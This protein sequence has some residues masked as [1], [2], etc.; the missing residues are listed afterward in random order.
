VR[1]V[2]ALDA[3]LRRRRHVLRHVLPRQERAEDPPREVVR[4]RW[5][6]EDGED[7]VGVTGERPNRLLDHRARHGPEQCLEGQGWSASW[8]AAPRCLGPGG[9]ERSR[10]DARSGA[11]S[12]R[13][14]PGAAPGHEKL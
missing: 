3:Q 5:L 9:S 8:G 1:D 6:S 10:P 11:D 2:P 14:P 12:R 4:I 7:K 13:A